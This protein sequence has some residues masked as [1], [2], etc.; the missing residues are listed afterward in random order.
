MLALVLVLL[1]TQVA[2]AR[3]RNRLSHLRVSEAVMLWQLCLDLMA[4][5]GRFG[6]VAELMRLP[7]CDRK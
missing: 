6:D 1:M 5:K 4:D 2:M 3:G 7:Y